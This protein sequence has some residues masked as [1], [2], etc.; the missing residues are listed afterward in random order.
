[1]Q[2]TAAVPG[3]A[4]VLIRVLPVVDPV[5]ASIS[6]PMVMAV[7]PPAKLGRV[8]APCPPSRKESNPAS[9]AVPVLPDTGKSVCEPNP[10]TKKK[11][12]APPTLV[13]PRSAS[14]SRRIST[15]NPF[16]EQ[17]IPLYLVPHII[18]RAIW[19][20]GDET[21][22]ISVIRTKK[23]YYTIRLRT[24]RQPAGKETK[25]GA[26]S[27]SSKNNQGSLDK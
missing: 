23:H 25:S 18:A 20:R 22:R 2:L 8:T 26:T 11:T 12:V 19:Q 17:D 24:T 5:L 16:V 10:E 15:S 6:I 1:M 7:K 27:R 3:N 14:V 21:F 9:P 4:S 13:R